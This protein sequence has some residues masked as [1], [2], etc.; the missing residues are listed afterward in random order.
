MRLKEKETFSQAR[1]R[2]I[3]GPVK[4]TEIDPVIEI[5]VVFVSVCKSI[6]D[7]NVIIRRNE[8]GAAKQVSF[9]QLRYEL[10]VQRRAVLK[11]F[12]QNLRD[13]KDQVLSDEPQTATMR[14]AVFEL[15]VLEALLPHDCKVRKTNPHYS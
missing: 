7:Q 13:Q 3:A 5:E 14:R 10:S 15:I 12:M 1:A 4:V 6:V 9:V 2:P 11:L 8:Q